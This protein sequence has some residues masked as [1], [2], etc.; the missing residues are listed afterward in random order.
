VS[1]DGV[2]DGMVRWRACW[3][4]GPAG[5]ILGPKIPVTCKALPPGSPDFG[6]RKLGNSSPGPPDV[7]S[8]PGLPC[9]TVN[10][11]RRTKLTGPTNAVDG[12]ALLL[13]LKPNNCSVGIG[14]RRLPF[15]RELWPAR[16]PLSRLTCGSGQDAPGHPSRTAAMDL[17]VGR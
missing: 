4:R 11:Q 1:I 5:V 7:P 3:K 2:T 6:L 13:P 12:Q 16:A 17:I 14:P 10:D 15:P 9:C 8:A